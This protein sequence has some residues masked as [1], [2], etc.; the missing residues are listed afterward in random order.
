MEVPRPNSSKSTRL[1]GHYTKLIPSEHNDY[2][3]DKIEELANIIL[4]SGGVKQNLLAR[5]R[6]PDEYELIAG[7]R[8]RLAVKYLVEQLGHEEFAM[9]PVHVEREGDILSEINLILTNSGARER[10]D[11]EKMQ[12]VGQII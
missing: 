8:R 7:H 5:K 12:E 9:V 6:T 1:R 11:Y 3:V 2:S 4:L 10:S